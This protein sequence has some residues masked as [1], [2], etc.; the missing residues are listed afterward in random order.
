MNGLPASMK[1][2]REMSIDKA[3]QS[4][5]NP[6]LNVDLQEKDDESEE[7]NM[8][9]KFFNKKMIR[10]SSNISPKH[11]KSN[12]ITI[13]RKNSKSNF[14]PYARMQTPITSDREG[15]KKNVSFD[16]TPKHVKAYRQ[17]GER[18]KQ[19]SN[20]HEP[21][22]YLDDEVLSEYVRDSNERKGR[23]FQDEIQ[24]EPIRTISRL[25]ET[26]T[27]DSYALQRKHTEL[28]NQRRLLEMN[29]HDLDYQ[30]P[31]QQYDYQLFEYFLFD[32]YKPLM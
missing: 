5:P 4:Q 15:S 29:D 31:P 26:G 30:I 11:K 20:L 14:R 25:K 28:E 22:E 18:G 2:L 19:F 21:K 12:S 8:E 6:P 13:A 7:L 24:P 16:M 10:S 1:K 3:R 17:I 23:K 32:I 9:L 27:P